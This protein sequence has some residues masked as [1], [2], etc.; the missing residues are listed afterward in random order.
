MLQVV[1]G[2]LMQPIA[3]SEPEVGIPNWLFIGIIVPGIDVCQFLYGLRGLS[4]DSEAHLTAGF[5]G[6]KPVWKS[7]TKT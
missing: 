7:P 5:G 3:V 2:P 1:L 4:P 6:C